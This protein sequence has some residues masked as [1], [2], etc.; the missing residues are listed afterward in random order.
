MMIA[1]N[2]S[3]RA[4]RDGAAEMGAPVGGSCSSGTRR[5]YRPNLPLMSSERYAAARSEVA[6]RA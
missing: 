1:A 3:A 6:A 4:V 5:S 2:A